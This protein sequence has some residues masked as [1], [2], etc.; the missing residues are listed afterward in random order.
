MSIGGG[1]VSEPPGC[2]K[3]DRESLKLLRL[4]KQ[5]IEADTKRLETC[6]KRIIELENEVASL[7][8]RNHSFIYREGAISHDAASRGMMS[9]ILPPPRPAAGGLVTAGGLSRSLS[10]T[11]TDGDLFSVGKGVLNVKLNA[12]SESG[13]VDGSG[14]SAAEG[15]GQQLHSVL[16]G[17]RGEAP[18]GQSQK[19]S[20]SLQELRDLEEGGNSHHSHR[21][22]THRSHK[23][24]SSNDHDRDHGRDHRQQSQHQHQHQHQSDSRSS[25]THSSPHSKR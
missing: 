3:S 20:G 19:K 16:A 14:Y 9:S 8:V 6:N 25:K 4:A 23:S 2:R 7:R 11:Q 22:S 13:V 10:K 21:S 1:G 24:S 15:V 5:R 18:G 12:I 17:D